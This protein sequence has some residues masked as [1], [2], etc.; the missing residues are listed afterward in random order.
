M[1]L[2]KI[3]VFIEEV[4]SYVKFYYDRASIKAELECHI[5]DRIA[6]YMEQ[7]YDRETAEQLS[8]TNMGEPKEIGL[9]LNKEHNPVLGYLWRF[10]EIIV[11]LLIIANIY[12]IGFTLLYPLFNPSPIHEF[13]KS[14]IVYKLDISEKVKIDDT[15]FHF[16]NIIYDINGDI[17]IFYKSYNTKLW[18]IGWNNSYIGEVTDNLG[19]V[20]LSGNGMS[21]SGLIT[22][23]QKIIDNFSKDADTLIIY[24]NRYNRKY[25]VEIPLKVGEISE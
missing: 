21:H 13:P 14:H 8:V 23:G 12:F 9:E 2:P 20:Y 3:D 18:G 17:N 5:S 19:T 6:D 25:Q 22:K 10:T 7:G 15:V 24:Y 11:S 4:L 16:T 1:P